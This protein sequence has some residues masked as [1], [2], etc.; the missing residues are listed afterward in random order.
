MKEEKCPI[1]ERPF[2]KKKL[3]PEE[4]IAK[5]KNFIVEGCNCTNCTSNRKE[6]A[7]LITKIK[8]VKA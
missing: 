6:I 8:E 7:E 5:L 4:E 1:C 2:E 3:S